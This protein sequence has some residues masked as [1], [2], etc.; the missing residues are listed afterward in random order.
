[1]LADCQTLWRSSVSSK[2]QILWPSS[3]VS[4]LVVGRTGGIDW[5]F[6]RTGGFWMWIRKKRTSRVKP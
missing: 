5:R 2:N 4:S 1:M 6:G 3:S